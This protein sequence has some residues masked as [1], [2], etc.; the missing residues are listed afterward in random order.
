MSAADVQA[1]IL[2]PMQQI[3]L[4]PRDMAKADQAGALRQYVGVLSRFD[5]PALA[6]AWSNVIETHPNRAW[7]LPSVIAAAAREALKERNGGLPKAKRHEGAEQTSSQRWEAWKAVSRTAMAMQAVEM[8][9]AWSLKCAVLHDGKGIDQINLR[10]LRSGKSSAERTAQNIRNGLPCEHK[11][12]MLTVSD[13]NAAAALRIW[14][15]ILMRETETQAEIC[16]AHRS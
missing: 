15:Q 16:A 9:V 8:N 10:E 12:R 5:G 1:Q 13:Q 2:E 7:P 6:V 3:F 4:P 11:G 14:D